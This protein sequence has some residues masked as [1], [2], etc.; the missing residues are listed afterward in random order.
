MKNEEVGSQVPAY[1]LP[2]R[3]WLRRRDHMLVDRVRHK[4]VVLELQLPGRDDRIAVGYETEIGARIGQR[5]QTAVRIVLEWQCPDRPMLIS[6]IRALSHRERH[7][8]VCRV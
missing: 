5:A 6:D 4:P 8:P 1:L 7:D 2:Q 3:A